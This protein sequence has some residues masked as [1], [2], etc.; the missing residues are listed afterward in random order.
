MCSVQ[1]G[2]IQPWRWHTA[3]SFLALQI[4]HAAAQ[5]AAPLL[6]HAALTC[7]TVGTRVDSWLVHSSTCMRATAGVPPSVENCR[8]AARQAGSSCWRLAAAI[9]KLA[10]HGGK[11]VGWANEHYKA[12][13]PRRLARSGAGAG[14]RAAATGQA[15]APCG[16]A[17]TRLRECRLGTAVPSVWRQPAAAAAVR[18]VGVPHPFGGSHATMA[19]P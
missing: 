1:A 17:S 3:G 12:A 15:P 16:V 13:P 10:V 6:S 18:P 19:Q 2:L 9:I 11:A 4:R 8:A 5:H 14:F 7:G